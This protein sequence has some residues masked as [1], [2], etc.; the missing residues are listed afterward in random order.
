MEEGE[1]MTVS[2]KA[3]KRCLHWFLTR[4]Q[5]KQR[6]VMYLLHYLMREDALLKHVHFVYDAQ[7]TPRGLL[8]SAQD[9]KKP[10]FKFYKHHLVTSEVD[11]AFHDIRLNK[12]EPLY[13]ELSF[14][15]VKRNLD[16][17]RVLE[18]NP[19]LPDDYYLTD[20]DR[21]SIDALLNHTLVNGYETWLRNEIDRS[22]DRNDLD[23]FQLLSEQLAQYLTRTEHPQK[24]QSSIKKK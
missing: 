14:E 12:E 19:Y 1:N 18:E 2:I 21:D 24:P 13:V 6:D 10:A 20:D 4:H 23:Q 5:V 11:K 9:G 7:Y 16:Y 8:I 15:G 3:K 22:L 17:H